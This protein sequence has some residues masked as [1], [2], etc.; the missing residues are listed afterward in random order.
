MC[1]ALSPPCVHVIGQNQS[2]MDKNTGKKKGDTGKK[3]L[4]LDWRANDEAAA[5]NL[6]NKIQKLENCKTIIEKEPGE[7][8]TTIYVI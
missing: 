1:F 5:W 3:L 8:F 7:V 6:L 2:I 4:Q